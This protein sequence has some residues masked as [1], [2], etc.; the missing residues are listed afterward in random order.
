MTIAA[1]APEGVRAQQ[2]A[3]VA[4]VLQ[5][6]YE[7]L[8][9]E[10]DDSPYGRPLH[11]GSRESDGHLQGDIHAVL[12]RPFEQLRIGLRS[13]DD[14]CQVLLLHPNAKQC[15]AADARIVVRFGRKLELSSEDAHPV[16]FAFEL[17]TDRADALQVEL[18]AGEGPLGT[19]DYR[20]TLDAVPLDGG[21]RSF[22]HLSY[23]YDFG[24]AARL[25]TE[26]Y[27]GTVGRNKVGFSRIAASHDRAPR[28]VKGLRGA[29]ERNAMRYYLAIDAHLGSLALPAGPRRS[30][31]RLR[32]WLASASA[33]EPVREEDPE[34]YLRTKRREFGLDGDAAAR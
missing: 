20:I 3:P 4:R 6:T 2:P 11:L 10:L 32:D 8:R 16:D 29:L 17:R 12:A 34:A 14:W 25:A 9:P 19:H 7:S 1:A 13:A 24:L 5:S 31:S 18:R 22:V 27:L 30:E 15:D 33:F 21:R 28:P 23:A 26:A